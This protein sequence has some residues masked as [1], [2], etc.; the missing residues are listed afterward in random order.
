METTVVRMYGVNAKGNS[1]V[2]NI[3]NFRPYFYMQLA[4]NQIIEQHHLPELKRY[5]NVKILL[6]TS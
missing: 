1:I 6:N 2:A 3:Y 4:F 5:L